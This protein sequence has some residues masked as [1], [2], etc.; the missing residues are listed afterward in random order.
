M[1]RDKHEE[2]RYNGQTDRNPLAKRFST[3]EQAARFFAS[4]KQI[5][6]GPKKANWR[7]YKAQAIA[8]KRIRERWYH[9]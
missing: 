4:T 8:K 2:K 3:P 5:Q 7:Y 6:A 9:G 1:G